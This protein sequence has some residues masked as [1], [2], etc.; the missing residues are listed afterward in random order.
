MQEYPTHHRS[1]HNPVSEPQ[2][3][4]I[5]STT[6]HALF[7]KPLHSALSCTVT[8]ACSKVNPLLVTASLIPSI[9]IIIGL[10]LPLLSCFHKSYALLVILSSIL[11][12]CSKHLRTH[13]STQPNNLFCSH[14]SSPNFLVTNPIYPGYTTRTL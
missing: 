7:T 2:F 10:P 14:H 5:H 13:I 12:S 4:A 6:F 8:L 11:S 9:Q 3:Y 1:P